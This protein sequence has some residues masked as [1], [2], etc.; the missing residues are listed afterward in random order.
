MTNSKWGPVSGTLMTSEPIEAYG[1]MSISSEML[2]DVAE[3]INVSGVPF[4]VDHKLSQPIR[5]RG[6]EAYVESRR[7][8]I[9]V[10]KFHA[11]IHEDDRHWLDTRVGVSASLT[12]PIARDQNF[13]SND[14]PSVRISADHAWFSDDALIA[15]EEQITA[16]GV[17]RRLIRVERAYQF[18]F[19]P[20]PQIFVDVVYPFL[21][22][23]GAGA[24]WDGIKKV[25]SQRKTP[26]GG[27]QQAST[28]VNISVKDGDRSLTAVVTTSDEVMA[29]RAL[30][31][32]D[33]A[34]TSFFENPPIT[35]PEDNRKPVIVWDDES[36]N[37]APPN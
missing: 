10:L 28:V 21:L 19:V 12:T 7:D 3:Y 1:G 29:E 11:E 27:D 30:R 32:L 33:G 18:S 2:R 6:F 23:L 34:V 24:L 35:D 4:H 37:W 25:F 13:A 14:N 36:R 9:D 5:M 16:Q 22:S 26:N 15:A 8:G 20:D 31:S 17:A